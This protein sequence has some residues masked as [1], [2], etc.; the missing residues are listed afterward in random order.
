MLGDSTIY[1]VVSSQLTL[2]I[3]NMLY[4]TNYT[5]AIKVSNMYGNQQRVLANFTLG[6]IIQLSNLF[7]YLT[8]F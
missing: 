2:Q 8:N 3:I 7:S 1:Y 4:N 6:N 5:I